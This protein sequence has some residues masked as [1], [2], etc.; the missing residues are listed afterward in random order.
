M[1]INTPFPSPR[2]PR[3]AATIAPFSIHHDVPRRFSSSST[4]SPSGGGGGGREQEQ[5]QERDI[6]QPSMDVEKE[7]AMA[8][9]GVQ[10]LHR[11]G[12]YKEVRCVCVCDLMCVGVCVCFSLYVLGEGAVDRSVDEGLYD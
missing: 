9:R 1:T 11:A 6:R 4:S 10:E 7:V 3:A 12:K 5:E 2:R 8:L